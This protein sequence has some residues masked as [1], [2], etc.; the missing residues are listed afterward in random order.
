MQLACSSLLC[1]V[2]SRVIMQMMMMM[3][4]VIKIWRFVITAWD[5]QWSQSS[6]PQFS[7]LTSIK[8]PPGL[9]IWELR[10]FIEEPRPRPTLS[11]RESW[12]LDWGLTWRYQDYSQSTVLTSFFRGKTPGKYSEAP[13]CRANVNW[14]VKSEYHPLERSWI[15]LWNDSENLKIG[16][17]LQTF[18]PPVVKPYFHL[19]FPGSIKPY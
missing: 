6:L 2:R 7:L 17:L 13:Y 9:Q 8:V 12:W 10:L 19:Q 14:I 5:L 3:M 18:D 11:A 15:H 4:F 16:F 1:D